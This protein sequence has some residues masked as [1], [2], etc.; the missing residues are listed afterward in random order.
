MLINLHYYYLDTSLQLIFYISKQAVE[1]GREE[2]LAEIPEDHGVEGNKKE[3]INHA[4]L[5]NAGNLSMS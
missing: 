5:S 4:E 2:K 3:L 1:K